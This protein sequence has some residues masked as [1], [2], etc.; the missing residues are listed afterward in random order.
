MKCLIFGVVLVILSNVTLAAD[1]RHKVHVAVAS[2][3]VFTLKQLSQKFEKQTGIDAIISTGSTGKLFAQIIH[4]APYDVFM[5]A[6]VLRAKKLE[7]QNIAIAGSRFTYATGKLVVW[8][9]QIENFSLLDISN[10]DLQR[11]AIANPKLAP[12]GLAA[13]QAMQKLG[14][15]E[16]LQTRLIRGENVSQALL[17]AQSGNVET[18]FVSHAAMIALNQNRYLSVPQNLYEP[19]DQQAVQLQDTQPAK[20]FLTFLQSSPAKVIIEKNGYSTH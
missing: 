20:A 1:T 5:S 19:I 18:A 9:P 13:K 14:L 12:Y 2:N 7:Q 16:T 8:H 17:F 3:F 11:I 6:D 4:G 10:S 15:W